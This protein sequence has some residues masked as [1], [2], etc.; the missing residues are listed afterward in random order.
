MIVGPMFAGKT[1]ELLRRVRRFSVASKN[2]LL[3]KHGNDI[4]FGAIG[5]RDVLTH[6]LEHVTSAAGAAEQLAVSSL[7]AAV[8]LDRAPRTVMV[9]RLLTDIPPADLVWADVIGID[10]GQF[11]PDLVEFC[12]EQANSGRICV[13]AALDGTFR[14]T[15]FPQVAELFCKAEEAIK[16]VAICMRCQIKEAPFSKRLGPEQEVEIIGGADKYISCCRR[17]YYAPA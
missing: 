1:N 10:E 4:R 14:R 17:C 9:M 11:F 6:D 13:V 15:P 2:V 16:L 3:V 8:L 12:D 7:P 5:A